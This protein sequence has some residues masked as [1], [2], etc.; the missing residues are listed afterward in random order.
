VTRAPDRGNAIVEFH[1]L[2]LVLL[3]PL[4][5]VLLAALDVQRTSY[6]A[7]QA[8]REAGR[9]F[10]VTGD[11]SAARHAA[12]VALRDQGVDVDAADVVIACSLS[13][14][15]Q[16]G[17]EVTVTVDAVVDLPFVPDILAGTVNAR[18]P[19]EATHVSV[20]DRFREL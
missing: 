6:G 16:A 18:I 17:S 13:P 19:V 12:W 9:I 4:V 14:C 7:T 11:E 15:H 8:A 10:V 1:L 2:G 20:V 5:Y 3:V